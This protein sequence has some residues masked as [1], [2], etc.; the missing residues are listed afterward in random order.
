MPNANNLSAITSLYQAC[1]PTESLHPGDERWVNFDDVRG[2]ENVV[3]L[4]ARSLRRARPE[5]PDFKLFTGHRGVGKTSELL[6]L[7]ELLES[8]A[9]SRQGFL[10]RCPAR[11]CRSAENPGRKRSQAATVGPAQTFRSRS[12]ERSASASEAG[13]DSAIY[14]AF[15]ANKH[16][17]RLGENGRDMLLVNNSLSRPYNDPRA[18]DT[19]DGAPDRQHCA[20]G[21][22][23]T[24]AARAGLGA[25]G[26]LA[27]AGLEH[28]GF[29]CVGGAAACA[30]HDDP[31][32]AGADVAASRPG[33][34]GVMC[35]WRARPGR[36]HWRPARA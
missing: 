5:R 32:R 25:R 6:R 3:E 7:K 29:H 14:F 4:Y 9:D 8:G 28:G 31:A 21:V 18:F 20:W 24:D 12:A 23:G 22:A 13:C 34:G 16:L 30:G 19:T 11:I 17:T 2:D 35:P 1:E 33:A 15:S 27:R 36:M 10:Q 26:R